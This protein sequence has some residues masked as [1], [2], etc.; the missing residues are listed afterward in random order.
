MARL[1]PLSQCL[2]VRVMTNNIT[3]AFDAV[4]RPVTNIDGKIMALISGQSTE[5]RS[6]TKRYVLKLKIKE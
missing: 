2:A 1:L 4:R 6:Q 5:I 3:V